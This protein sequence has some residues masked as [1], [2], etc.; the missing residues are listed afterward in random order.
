MREAWHV[1]W[2]ELNQKPK[3]PGLYLVQLLTQWTI[4]IVRVQK[5]RWQNAQNPEALY[6]ENCDLENFPEAYW[7]GPIPEPINAHP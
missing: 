1:G 2:S 3:E 6:A 7:M 4:S 5:G